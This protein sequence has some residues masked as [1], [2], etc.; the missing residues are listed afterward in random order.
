MS[1]DSYHVLIVGGGQAG[2]PLARELATRGFRV[3]LAERR[4]LGGSCVNFGCTPTKAAIASARVAHLARRGREFGLRVPLV[5]VDFAAVLERAKGILLQSRAGLREA[6]HGEGKPE[7]LAGHARLVGRDGRLF[8]VAVGERH[9]TAEQVVLDT[10]TRTRLP[11]IPG[12]EEVEFLHAGNWLERPELPA[13]L[14]VLGAGFVGLEMAQLYRRL[15]SRVTV[16]TRGDLLAGEDRDVARAV[17]QM[18]EAEDIRFALDVEAERLGAGKDGVRLRFADSRGHHELS[19]S[20]LF[21]A[22][23]RRPNTDDLGLET[24]GLRTTREGFVRVDDRLGTSVAGVWA[25][26]DIRGG[27]MFTHTAW[28]DHRVL[29]SQLAGDRRRTC[30]RVPVYAL[31]TDPE[32]GRVGATEAEARRRLPGSRLRVGRHEMRANG[33]A[34]ERGDSEGFVRVLVDA[35]SERVVGASV[36]AAEGAE[37]VHCFVEVMQAGAS[38]RAILDAVHIHPTL[39]EAVQSAVLALEVPD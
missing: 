13:H 31:F 16:V 37:I 30:Q 5:E 36:L 11:E 10:G 26:G 4:E 3:A 20:H 25:A 14:I 39:A 27:P 23:G 19:G 17:R 12:L 28:D 29:L 1:C 15:G 18:L 8:R 24:V 22:T 9:V 33:R 38:Y 35:E 21:V 7:L 34:R 6:F 32:L 2:I